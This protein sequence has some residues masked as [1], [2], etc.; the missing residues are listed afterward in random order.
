MRLPSYASSDSPS[1]EPSPEPSR[2][3][4]RERT[5]SARRYDGIAV[6]RLRGRG[7]V[8]IDL[9]GSGL[10][11]LRRGRFDDVSFE[12]QG[13]PRYLSADCVHISAARGRL[14]LE[15]EELELEFRGGTINASLTGEFEVEVH[16]LAWGPARPRGRL[17]QGLRLEGIERARGG[18]AA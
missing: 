3:P 8:V 2:E 12:G 14:V 1:P 4:S 15:G 9:K 7:R 10:L 18:R 13:V 6:L 17:D 16:G 5:P 11:T